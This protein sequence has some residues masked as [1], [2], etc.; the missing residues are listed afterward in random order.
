MQPFKASFSSVVIRFY[1]MMG[2]IISGYFTGLYFLA[3]LALPVFLSCLLAIRFSFKV[4]AGQSLAV[5][6]V[7]KHRKATKEMK[8]AA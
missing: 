4:F 8:E 5:T 2:L 7:M 1:L 3:F 6:R